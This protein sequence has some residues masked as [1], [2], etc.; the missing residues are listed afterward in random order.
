MTDYQLHQEH[1]ALVP[2]AVLGGAAAQRFAKESGVFLDQGIA[3][4]TW[5][6]LAV[7]RAG[8]HWP[9]LVPR[10]QVEYVVTTK[11]VSIE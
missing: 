5:R 6:S 4:A 1:V 2:L 8:I 10:T 3:S 7:C 9:R 11:E